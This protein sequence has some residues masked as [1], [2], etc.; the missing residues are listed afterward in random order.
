MDFVSI[1]GF[2]AATIT[3]AGFLPQTIKTVK[4]KQ[5]KDVSLWMYLILTVG[6]T[7]WFTYGMY[8]Q[9][10]PIILANGVTLI[11][12]IPVLWIKIRYK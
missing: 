11:F 2:M 12:I 5:A 1:I 4:T 3:T 8:K 10:W 9:D 6:V 7:L